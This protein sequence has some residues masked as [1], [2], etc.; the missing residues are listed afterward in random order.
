M[1]PFTLCLAL[2]GVFVASASA[3]PP[4]DK[5]E[6]QRYRSVRWLY[7]LAP[8]ISISSILYSDAKTILVGPPPLQRRHPNL[9][10]E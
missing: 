3:L 5:R 9:Q 2:V 10:P 8:S 1:R 7:L 4:I 6:I